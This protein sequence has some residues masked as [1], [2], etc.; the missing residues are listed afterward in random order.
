MEKTRCS[1][2]LVISKNYFFVWLNFT[3]KSTNCSLSKSRKN[4]FAIRFTKK[5]F[6]KH[7]ENLPQY[8]SGKFVGDNLSVSPRAFLKLSIIVIALVQ[9][10][11]SCP[12]LGVAWFDKS[13]HKY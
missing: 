4:I 6:V 9:K 7:I 12:S 3:A 11:L 10:G 2:R 13:E 1:L 5:N 8:L